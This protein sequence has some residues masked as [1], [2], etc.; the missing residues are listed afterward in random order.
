MGIAR[1]A[2]AVKPR[3]A[4]EKAPAKIYHRF[5]AA[6]RV[7]GPDTDIKKLSAATGLQ[8]S[9]THR[10][11][12]RRGKDQW[13]DSMWSFRSSCPETASL[14]EHLNSL[15]DRLAPVREKL[16]A[17]IPA[18]SRGIFWC[19]HYTNA[20]EGLAGTVKLGVGV[21]KRLSSFEFDFALDTYSDCE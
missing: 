9:E 7:W 11:G 12:D 10:K 20:P 5:D 4:S 19:A 2:K 17:A 1:K 21:L 3:A 13:N 16:L 18:R 14:E 6:F 8:P 15:L